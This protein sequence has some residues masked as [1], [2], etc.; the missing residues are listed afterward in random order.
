MFLKDMNGEEILRFKRHFRCIECPFERCYPNQTQVYTMHWIHC[1][2]NVQLVHSFV[3][4]SNWKFLFFSG[5]WN[6]SSRSSSWLCS[7]TANRPFSKETFTGFRQHWRKDLWYQWITLL[8][9]MFWCCVWCKLCYFL[10]QYFL[11]PW[12]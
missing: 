10:S 9:H 7:R 1:I 8:L 11:Q 6:F 4:N 2:W 12:S 3:E 5:Y